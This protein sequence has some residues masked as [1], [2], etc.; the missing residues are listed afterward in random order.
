[1]SL[2]KKCPLCGRVYDY[3]VSYCEF[4]HCP[5]CGS[6]ALMSKR[7]NTRN[8]IIYS[9]GTTIVI[10][11]LFIA[12]FFTGKFLNPL[13]MFVKII[14]YIGMWGISIFWGYR[15]FSPNKYS[16]KNCDKKFDLPV[17]HIRLIEPSK[18]CPF[19]GAEMPITAKFCGNCGHEF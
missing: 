4:N 1:M 8:F 7:E 5:F 9:I 19:C 12:A 10:I 11:V 13:D 18:T 15:I 6:S 14:I 3:D 2:G 17:T 16:C